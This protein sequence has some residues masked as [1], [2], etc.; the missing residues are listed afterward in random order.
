M[1]IILYFLNE[2]Y[3]KSCI[4]EFHFK[5]GQNVFSVF[6]VDNFGFIITNQR[7]K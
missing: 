2:F 4:E 7:G 1:N 6:F 3:H 5:V